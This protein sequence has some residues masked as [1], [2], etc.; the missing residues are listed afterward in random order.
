VLD[1]F[2]RMVPQSGDFFALFERHSAACVAA[3]E[4]LARLTKGDGDAAR[5]CAEIQ[6]RE[7]DADDIIREVLSEV[8]RWRLTHVVV[9]IAPEPLEQP[10]TDFA[11]RHARKLADI[12]NYRI[13]EV[14]AAPAPQD[15]PGAR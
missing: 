4:A 12:G 5:L 3:A 13:A 14:V 7:H 8:R 9:A 11:A 2:R 1:W 10:M 15:A 6:D